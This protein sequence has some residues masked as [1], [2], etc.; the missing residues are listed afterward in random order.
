MTKLIRPQ[1]VKLIARLL[2][3]LTES[4]LI[5]VPEYRE[6]IAQLQHLATHGEPLPVVVPK[7]INQNEAADM[8][9][10]SLSNFKKLEAEGAF[11]FKR[12]M[13]GSAVR[14]RNTDVL[15]YMFMDE[16]E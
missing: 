16:A 8:L 10:I 7:M 4:N 11:P 2:N 5:M 13:V 1:T 3:P 14:Y 6:I 15:R 12:R 9:G